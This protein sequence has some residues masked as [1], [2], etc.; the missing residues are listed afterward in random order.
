MEIRTNFECSN[1]FEFF[2]FI[3]NFLPIAA[4]YFELNKTGSIIPRASHNSISTYEMVSIELGEIIDNTDHLI[5]QYQAT[6]KLQ[7]NDMSPIEI[8]NTERN[9]CTCRR[10]DAG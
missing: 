2:H 6:R 5:L 4:V 8:R 7:N 9:Q 10:A 1:E 3:R